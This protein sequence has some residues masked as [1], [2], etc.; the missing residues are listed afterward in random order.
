MFIDAIHDL[1]IAS[2]IFR[3]WA[4]A[5]STNFY[6]LQASN[7]V[8]A[9]LYLLAKHQNKQ[10]KLREEVLS[11]SDRRPYLRACIKEGMRVMPVVS[12]NIRRTTK[13]YNLNGYLIPKDVSIEFKMMI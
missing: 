1:A 8:M 3:H 5:S 4:I 9:T 13:E 6:Y 12:G 7:T 10:D 2:P 11:K